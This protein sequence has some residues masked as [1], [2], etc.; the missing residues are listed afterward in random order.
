MLKPMDG[1][2]REQMQAD[3]GAELKHWRSQ[4]R[5]SQLD[6]GLSANV[7]A[8]HISFLET[9]R[10]RPSR[11]MVLNLCAEL[12]VPRGARNHMLRAAGLA[13][14]YGARALSDDDMAPVREAVAWML[15][16][17]MPYPAFAVNRHWVVQSVNP[18]ATMLIG[19]AGLDVGD[20]LIDALIE[21]AALRSALDNLDEIIQHAL[22]R[23]R[24]ESAHLGGDPVLE[25]AITR[26]ATQAESTAN[27]VTGVLPAAIPT[28]YKLGETVLS[29][30]STIT[31]FGTAEDVA[32]SEL[33]I[34]MLFPADAATRAAIFAMADQKG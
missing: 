18:A 25:S 6:L 33:K 1:A 32:L 14:A 21:S 2:R 17:H 31:Q 29:F 13:P 20:S 28:R 12:D 34:E 30:F 4:R 24:T 16:R 10:A 22:Q 15:A 19:A 5:M 27:G 3:F 23:L 7:S 9:G 26:L 11:A 8:R